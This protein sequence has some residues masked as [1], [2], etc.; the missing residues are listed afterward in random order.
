MSTVKNTE[1]KTIKKTAKNTKKST[2]KTHSP[3][4][5]FLT[6]FVVAA[7]LYGCGGATDGMAF[8]PGG[9]FVMGSK[10]GSNEGP[11]G[12]PT[13][14]SVH[15]PP[16]Y[17]DIREVTEGDYRVF[18]KATSRKGA[19]RKEPRHWA[20]KGFDKKRADHPMTFVSFEDAGGYCAWK[21]SRLPIEAEWEKAARGVDGRA[22]PW[23]D[24]FDRRK[25]NTSLS[26]VTG[27]V[28][29]GS[30]GEGGSPYGVLDMAGNVWEWTATSYGESRK[31]VKGGSWGLSHRF[32][33]TFTRVGYEPG[34]K[35]NN[36]G[37]RCVRSE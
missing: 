23:G 16:F 6:L 26:G 29:V 22:Y 32:A 9:E 5:S 24:G 36:L 19:G 25:A 18:F 1:K 33:R 4:V 21:G 27:T 7:V 28:D 2:V 20:L 17:I 8:V 10:T 11:P 30:Y 31:T 14:R 3:F 13:E 12:D 37:F 35:I 15:V 34:V